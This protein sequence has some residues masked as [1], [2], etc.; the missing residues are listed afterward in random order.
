MSL[1]LIESFLHQARAKSGEAVLFDDSNVWTWGEL[2][3][4]ASAVARKFSS[5]LPTGAAVMLCAPNQPAFFAAYLGVLMAGNKIFPISPDS[6]AI[7]LASAAHDGNVEGIIGITSS[8]NAMRGAVAMHIDEVADK[9]WNEGQLHDQLRDD[10]QCAMLLTSSGTTGK[11][12]IAHRNAVS[13]NG[14][15]ASITD[16]VQF[17]ESDRVLAAVPLCHAYGVEHSLLAAISAGAKVH[18]LRGFELSLILKSLRQGITVFPGVPFMYE[19]LSHGVAEDVHLPSLRQAYSAGSPLPLSV[20]DAF[21]MRFGVP[22]GQVYGTTETGSSTFNDPNSKYFDANSVGRAMP[23]VVLKI[24]DGQVTIMST[25]MFDRYTAGDTSEITPDGYFLTGDLGRIDKKGN[26]HITGRLKLLIDVGGQKV[27]PLEVEQALSD[28]PSV[29][30]CVVLPMNLSP[31]VT[32]LKALVVARP[33][34]PSPVA[35]EL[36]TFLKPR[37]SNYKIP[38]IFEVRDSLPQ[39][40]AGKISRHRIQG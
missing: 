33:G 7:E 4:A 9:R 29:A 11:P 40:P 20:S 14:I 37:L 24:L 30:S 16:A 19:A 17:D 18:I 27:N 12:K 2:H 3:A 15:V 13:L 21:A 31:T 28:H 5:E 36:R 6:T 34:M 22:I 35:Q 25:G 38:R 10:S 26:L 32:R 23:G 39:S 1:L 8:I